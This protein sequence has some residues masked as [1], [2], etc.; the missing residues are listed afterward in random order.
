MNAL[1]CQHSKFYCPSERWYTFHHD[2]LLRHILIMM[3][4]CEARQCQSLLPCVTRGCVYIHMLFLMIR[5]LLTHTWPC[6]ERQRKAWVICFTKFMSQYLR[7][8]DSC[9]RWCLLIKIGALLFWKATYR[10]VNYDL[11]C[12]S[13]SS[14]DGPRCTYSALCELTAQWAWWGT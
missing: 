2:A 9:H 1:I 3:L 10:R 14:V 13:E 4:L 8:A 12:D 5:I 6:R 7:P 11:R